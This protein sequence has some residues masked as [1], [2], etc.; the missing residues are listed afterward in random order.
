MSTSRRPLTRTR[1]QQTLIDRRKKSIQHRYVHSLLSF[2]LDHHLEPF[3]DTSCAICDPPSEIV[4]GRSYQ[5]I[6]RTLIEFDPEI[7]ISGKNQ[8]DYFNLRRNGN[9]NT[10][11][12]KEL[13]ES[14]TF[15]NIPAN[16]RILATSLL[17]R[18]SDTW[19]GQ[20]EELTWEQINQYHNE[21]EEYFDRQ[22]EEQAQQLISQNQNVSNFPAT[23]APQS[24]TPFRRALSTSNLL[25][26]LAGNF[27]QNILAEE[28]EEQ[29]N[30]DQNERPSLFV[31]TRDSIGP[32]DEESPEYLPGGSNTQAQ[33]P[34]TPESPTNTEA[35]Q[36]EENELSEA[37]TIN[38]TE[39]D[40]QYLVHDIAETE[41]NASDNAEEQEV[42]V[43]LE[44]EDSESEPEINVQPQVLPQ[45]QLHPIPMARNADYPVF[46]GTKPGAWIKTMEIAF[47]ANGVA[48]AALKINI[49]AAHLG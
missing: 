8:R 13:L 45:P 39:L 24:H 28:S 20:I 2:P 9:V 23:P 37:E 7:T 27:L 29:A 44:S 30:N 11:T 31:R 41:S 25:Y 18:N 43:E 33:V 15:I 49:A 26:N 48:Q 3:P 4:E 10:D 42:I 19:I 36:N 46:D 5:R 38:N 17:H 35:T 22:N 47:A 1:T 6:I 14:F 32:L 21:V 16:Y 40:P 34:N 12:L